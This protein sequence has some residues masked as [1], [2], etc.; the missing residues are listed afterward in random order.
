MVMIIK[1]LSE[2]R[3]RMGEHSEKFNKE[4]KNIKKNRAENT[5]TEIKNTLGRINNRSEDTDE[6]ITKLED[7]IVENNTFFFQEKRY[8][9]K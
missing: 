7:R 5:V 6:Q 2:F 9:K 1:M 8:F 4:L 3:R